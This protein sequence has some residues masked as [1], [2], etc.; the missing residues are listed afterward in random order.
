ME[1]VEFLQLAV[2][3]QRTSFSTKRFQSPSGFIF[4]MGAASRMQAALPLIQLASSA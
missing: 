2:G 1:D 3:N 4:E